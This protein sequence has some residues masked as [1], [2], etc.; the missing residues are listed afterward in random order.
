MYRV[1]TIK[2]F[3]FTDTSGMYD[4]EFNVAGGGMAGQSQCMAFSL[5][6]ALMKVNPQHRTILSK[7]GLV[8]YDFRQKEAKKT[9]LYSARVRPPYVR[10]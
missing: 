4:A 3:V 2:P 9:N 5:A 7:F 6:R 10:R 8:G 1:E